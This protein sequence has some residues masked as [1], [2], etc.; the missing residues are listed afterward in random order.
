M[1]KLNV[2]VIGDSAMWGQGLNTEDKFYF[3]AA[4]RIA[5][6]LG[7]ELNLFD[8]N[9]RS[10]AKII[11]AKTNAERKVVI[12]PALARFYDVKVI[13]VVDRRG[14]EI[15]L[16]SGRKM[17][18]VKGDRAKFYD[19]YPAF[20]ESDAQV[21]AF[22]DGTNEDP[23]RKLF[24]EVP[25][26]F[27][28]IA[29]QIESID[30]ALAES[31]DM[32]IMDGSVN[33][34]DFEGVLDSME[35]PPIAKIDLAIRAFAY[36]EFK[37]V[38]AKARQ[39]F[40]RAILLLTGYFSPFS[41]KS[42]R[43]QLERMAKHFSGRSD[44]ELWANDV[45]TSSWGEVLLA[46]ISIGLSFTGKETVDVG[47]KVSEAIERSEFAHTRGVYWLRRAV[48]ELVESGS[49]GPG[50]IFVNPGFR[51]EHSLFA[52]NSLLHE[53]Y[54]SPE[55]TSNSDRVRDAALKDRLD[56]I[57]RR[58]L[59]DEMDRAHKSL[60]STRIVVGLGQILGDAQKAKIEKDLTALLSKLDGPISLR[61]RLAEVLKNLFDVDILQRAIDALGRDIGRIHHAE[62]GSFIHPNEAGARRY[63]DKLLE[64]YNR[65]RQISVRSELSKLASSAP[66]QPA[67]DIS[68]RETLRR[69]SLDAKN[70]LL[71]CM[72][73]MIVD[74]IAVEI[75]SLFDPP[76]VIQGAFDDVFLNVGGGKRFRLNNPFGRLSTIDT[77]GAL[78]L[79]DIQQ[80][81]LEVD[82]LKMEFRDF[83][84]SINGKMVFQSPQTRRLKRGDKVT[85]AY[86][87]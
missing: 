64:R 50:L 16:P 15:T 14:I 18:T 20:F 81:I 86:P 34:V 44:F 47:A 66:Q 77:F 55:E 12:D 39:K 38:V 7:R 28:T 72:Q 52:S 11:A 3:L 69:Y 23:A 5:R 10:G 60:I 49:A 74:S 30:N 9:P 8:V 32:V 53:G 27:P 73:H 46:P 63:T 54:K 80:L 67:G 68:V 82:G 79:G 35:G 31:I 17:T 45:L 41:Q 51:P 21:I 56:A 22:L 4:N 40:P 24:G 57:P 75:K 19:T 36:E 29:Y 71:S 13:S 1:D 59:V 61:D 37:K 85:F 83:R 84:L 25:A 33:D 70:G 87:S 76:D 48:S 62:I 65:H 6:L 2:A 78:H 43:D 26:T 58:D 42:D